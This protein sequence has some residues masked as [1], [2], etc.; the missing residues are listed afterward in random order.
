MMAAVMERCAGI[1]VGKVFWS[2]ASAILSSPWLCVQ[3]PP[4]LLPARSGTAGSEGCHPAQAGP[5]LGD[6]HDP[7]VSVVARSTKQF[8]RLTIG[9]YS[10][11][12]IHPCTPQ[13]NRFKSR[14]GHHTFLLTGDTEVM[15]QPDL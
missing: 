15:R 4:G 13:Q 2:L 6:T 9:A 5:S 12:V 10:T 3:S 7:V 11:I 1:D 8:E 14:P